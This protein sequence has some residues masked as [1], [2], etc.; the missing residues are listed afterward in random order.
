M[1]EGSPGV[2]EVAGG[3]PISGGEPEGG[4]ERCAVIEGLLESLRRRQRRGRPGRMQTMVEEP[5][6]LDA[7][8][9]EETG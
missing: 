2:V 7:T 6:D 3:N 1:V 8:A 5:S 4:I 9:T